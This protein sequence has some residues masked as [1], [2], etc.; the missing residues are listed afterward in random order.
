M[1]EY[2]GRT[3]PRIQILC[4]QDLIE[5]KKPRMPASSTDLFARPERER[6]REGVQG[7]LT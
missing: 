5:G 1:S 2:D 3:Y 7:R 4:A 6:R